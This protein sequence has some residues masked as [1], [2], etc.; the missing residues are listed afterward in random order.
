MQPMKTGHTA[1]THYPQLINGLF[2]NY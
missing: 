1:G 2:C